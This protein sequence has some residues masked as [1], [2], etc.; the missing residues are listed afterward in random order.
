MIPGR[1][2]WPL[3][4]LLAFALFILGTAGLIVLASSQRSDLVSAN[5][6]EEEIKYQSRI[7]SLERAQHLGSR[8][9]I[10]YSAG[11]RC[12]VVTLPAEHAGRPVSGEVQLYRPSAAGL[13]RQFRLEP[14]AHGTQSFDAADL[15]KGL[16]KIRVTWRIEGQEYSLD[17][18]LVIGESANTRR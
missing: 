16:W 4:I 15:P 13:D 6:Y 14:D 8:A 10:T 3:G 18:K 7:D 12:L 1:N 17:Q 5:Y 9:A 2:C 11:A